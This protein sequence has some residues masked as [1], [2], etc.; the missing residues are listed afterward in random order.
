VNAASSSGPLLGAHRGPGGGDA[1]FGARP[2]VGGIEV[3]GDG[4]GGPVSVQRGGVVTVACQVVPRSLRTS[5]CFCNQPT[6]VTCRS[7]VVCSATAVWWS[8]SAA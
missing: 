3:V 8:P 6:S 5:A 1:R 2:L 4:Q 7:A